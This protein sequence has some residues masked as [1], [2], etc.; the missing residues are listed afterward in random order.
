LPGKILR[1]IKGKEVL[2]YIY[3]RLLAVTNHNNIIV[4]T[5]YEKSDDPVVHFC[6]K[7]NINIYRGSLEN[8]A[9]RFLNC[10]LDNGFDY[11]TRI[12][13]DNVFIDIDTIKEMSAIAKQGQY[14]FITNVKN[15]T[16]PKGMSIEIVR[17][18]YFKNMYENFNKDKFFEHVTLFL[19]NLAHPLKHYY[20]FNKIEPKAAGIQLALDTK[21]DFN[22]FTKIIHN[23]TK[24]HTEY[25]LYEVYNIYKNI[26]E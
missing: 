6:R 8:V 7:K 22:K 20:H 10:A 21:E 2:L 14:N 13:G 9:L 19:Y 1:K 26:R 15:R 5:S 12:N 4:A 18:D 17:T 25:G 16:F 23:F 3:E 24:D 11:A